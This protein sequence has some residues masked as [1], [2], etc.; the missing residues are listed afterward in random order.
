MG[1][2]LLLLGLLSKLDFSYYRVG[3][4]PLVLCLE[5]SSDLLFYNTL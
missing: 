2:I 1:C 5:V 3:K 4:R